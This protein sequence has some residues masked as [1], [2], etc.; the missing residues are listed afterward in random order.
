MIKLLLQ[1]LAT[2]W[3]YWFV[4]APSMWAQIQFTADPTGTQ[5]V[6]PNVAVTGRGIGTF[7]LTGQ[8]LAFKVTVDGLTGPI[9]M[10]HFH[11]AA[12]GVDG[13]VVKTITADFVGNIASGIWKSTDPEPL[14]QAL[15][16]EL[17]AARLYVNIHTASFPGGE[18]RGQL[19][20]ATLVSAVLPAS[21][22]VQVGVPATAFATIINA[23]TSTAIGCGITPIPNIPATFSYQTT[24][25]ATNQITGTPNTPVD[26]PTGLFQT[27][28]FSLTP[29]API[30]PVDL[31]F[32]FDCVNT[33][34]A[35]ITVGVN[36]LLFTASATPVPDVVALAGTPAP[37]P[38]IVNIPGT[39]GTGFFVV[40]TVNVGASGSITASADTGG[41]VL[42][43]NISLCQTNPATG[44]CLA[45]QSSTVTTTIDANATPTFGIFVQGAS[46]V[47]F[48][49]ATS[50][51][52]VR[53]K[54]AG[55]VT[56]GSTSVA[57][58]TQ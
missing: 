7:T 18:I 16:N 53:F 9:A 13:A 49:P 19:G 5:E 21:R 31:Q 6:P 42:P 20:P 32:S 52:F 50:R 34:P 38:G 40:A 11:N 12:V 29:N 36:T 41:T 47:A 33:N 10:A 54:D 27:Y 22:S 58:R 48:N 4:L 30:T 23:A 8:E 2:V 55:N 37:D 44:V 14:T 24:N 17:Q 51:I 57:V 15:I 1:F 56:R 3:L 46:N 26:I 25:P 28:V 43:V 39:T 35:P 45:P